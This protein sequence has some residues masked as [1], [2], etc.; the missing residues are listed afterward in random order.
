VNSLRALAAGAGGDWV[1][2]VCAFGAALA[3]ADNAA[4]AGCWAAAGAGATAA[5]VG[6]AG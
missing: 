4:L 2:A 1:W 3:G 5:A 6:G